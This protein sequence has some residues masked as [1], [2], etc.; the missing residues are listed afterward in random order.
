MLFNSWT[1]VVF[2]PLVLALYWGLARF[3]LHRWVLLA[4]SVVFYG[5]WDVRFLGLLALSVVVDWWVARSLEE[6]DQAHGPGQARR[7]PRRRQLL[8]FSVSVNLGVL[9]LFKYLD[10]FSESLTQLLG[11]VGL[12]ANPWTLDLVLP[13][14]ISFY[15]FQSMAYTIDVFR[16][17]IKAR[18]NV[19]DVALYVS[20]FP[21]LVAGPIERAGR[22]MPQ[23]TRNPS[24]STVRV[25]PALLLVLWGFYKKL[26]VADNLSGLVAATLDQ[27]QPN[28]WQLTVGVA[29]F[30]VQIYCDFSGYTDIARGVARLFGISLIENFKLPYF[31]R[32][33]S[34]FWRR[35]HV[36]LST[37]LRDYLYIPL[38]GNR[39]GRF[40]V[41]RNLMITMLLG[42]LWHGAGFNFVLWG[43]FHGAI[44]IVYRVVFGASGE[45]RVTG[46]LSKLT[47]VSVMQLLT[48]VGWA[49]FRAQEPHQLGAFA[50]ALTQWPTELSAMPVS[51][52]RDT[53]FLSLGVVLVMLFKHRYGLELWDRV[54]RITGLA[55]AV[56]L[57]GCIVAFGATGGQEFIYFQF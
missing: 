44:L 15:T 46:W 4:A 33:P 41:A 1:F 12:A 54:G 25:G 47:A 55:V 35:W 11:L 22:L 36:S 43:A 45:P 16:G 31:A 52:I 53:A 3:G 26:V 10:F 24:W 19:W 8:I 51:V 6:V 28:G 40:F 23:L 17:Q 32:S 48:L 9:A 13:M 42:G 50:L 38:G 56:V 14:G 49:I 29:A 27:P 37:W 20:F 30:A 2:L 5:F 57:I 21:Q 18:R 39:G 34:D 7:T